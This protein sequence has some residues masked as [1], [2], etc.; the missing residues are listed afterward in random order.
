[1][2]ELW[3]FERYTNY[4]NWSELSGLVVRR[5][6]FEYLIRTLHMLGW[7]LCTPTILNSTFN[8]LQCFCQSKCALLQVV[9][10]SKLAGSKIPCNYFLNSWFKIHGFCKFFSFGLTYTI[11]DDLFRRVSTVVFCEN[12]HNCGI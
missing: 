2:L 9:E 6:Y 3:L 5:G 1:M 11:E 10:E 12:L 4:H 8:N 7:V